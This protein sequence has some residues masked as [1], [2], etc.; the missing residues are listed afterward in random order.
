MIRKTLT[1]T[2][3]A[4]ALIATGA[5]RASADLGDA[6]AGGII[7]GAIVGAIQSHNQRQ[8]ARATAPSARAVPSA[9]RSKPAR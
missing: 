4:A 8:P 9:A 6:I 2:A 1:T 5:G 7:G 3:L